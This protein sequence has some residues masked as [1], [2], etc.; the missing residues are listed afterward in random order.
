MGPHFHLDYPADT[1]AYVV[2]NGPDVFERCV[3]PYLRSEIAENPDFRTNDPLDDAIKHAFKLATMVCWNLCSFWL[4]LLTDC[5]FFV[6]SR[7]WRT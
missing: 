4:C 1:V 7:N 5:V 2:I 6:F 3:V